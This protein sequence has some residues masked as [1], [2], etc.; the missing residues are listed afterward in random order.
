MFGF[1]FLRLLSGGG[2]GAFSEIVREVHVAPSSEV[3][4]V[5]AFH[6][7]LVLLLHT[8]HAS[9]VQ[10]HRLVIILEGAFLDFDVLNFIFVV[11]ELG[12][13]L[14]LVVEMR[15]N[16][17]IDAKFESLA[18]LQNVQCVAI[19]GKRVLERNICRHFVFQQSPA[20]GDE[21]D[22]AGDE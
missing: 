9:D 10:L 11:G 13:G 21:F 3:A 20:V 6:D 1:H 7:R 2:C 4:P 15:E 12:V 22:F 8:P 5:L 16:L 18:L 14:G 19:E 17:V